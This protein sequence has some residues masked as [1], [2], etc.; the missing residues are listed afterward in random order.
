MMRNIVLPDSH[1]TAAQ[2][3]RKSTRRS[4]LFRSLRFEWLESRELLFAGDLDSAFGVGGKVITEFHDSSAW[5]HT[6]YSSVMQTNGKIVAAG[7]GALSRYHSDGSLDASFGDGGK[8]A[9]PYF[10]RSVALQSDGKIVVAGSVSTYGVDFAVARYNANGTVDTTFDT[11]GMVTTD[12]GSTIDQAYGVAVQ[13][14][15]KILVVGSSGDSLAVV[16]YDSNGT[17]DS[18]FNGDGKLLKQIH[19]RDVVRSVAVQ[20]DGRI[21][22]AGQSFDF[23]TSGS[24]YDFL[25]IRLLANGV[26]DNS[27]DGDGQTTTGFARIDVANSVALQS[28][29]KIVV[30]GTAQEFSTSTFAVARYNSDGKLDTTFDADGVRTDTFPYV[31]TQ[32]ND[33]AVQIDGRIVVAGQSG[34]QTALIRYNP[35]GGL[36]FSFGLAGKVLGAGGSAKSVSLQSDGKP[37]VAGNSAGK[38]SVARYS[39]NGSSDPTFSVDGRVLTDFGP[40]YDDATAMVLQNDGKIIVAGQSERSFALARYNSNGS[41]DKSFSGDGKLTLDFGIDSL[42]SKATSVALQSDGKI[43]VAGYVRFLVGDFVYSDFAVARL[44]SDGS[45]DTSFSGDGKLITDLG[46]FDNAFAVAV[47][48]N[49]KILVGGGTNEGFALVRFNPDGSADTSFDADGKQTTPF[50]ASPAQISSLALQPDGK[51]LAAGGIGLADVS[52]HLTVLAIARYN[53][54]GSLDQ[55]FDGDGIVLDSGSVQRFASDIAV[56]KD[57]RIVV[58]GGTEELGSSGNFQSNFAVSRYLITGARDSSFGS[59]GTRVISFGDQSVANRLAL[60]ADNSVLAAGRAGDDFAL[61]R[62]NADGTLDSRFAGDGKLTTNFRAG[63]FTA[64]SVA[65]QRDG[66][67]VAA[68]SGTK[69]SE[70]YGGQ[71]FCSGPIPSGSRAD[72]FDCGRR[73]CCRWDH[74]ERPVESG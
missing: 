36:D 68:G 32:A 38:F 70:Q 53:L 74:C 12:L 50:D 37:V 22:L 44:N 41:L 4:Q 65:I 18:G 24:N 56:Q 23:H 2:I 19:T 15:G 6:A 64:T 16:R 27:F 7:E 67:I 45:L 33:V 1:S 34:N 51:I 58:S 14:N 52:E 47:Q 43:V 59:N 28:N 71:R 29:G 46:D 17:L 63:D 5:S 54:N 13:A 11:D 69:C 25:V 72:F 31:G 66:M 21:V 8:V 42:E 35:I 57:S 9:F 3:P 73:E 10:A 55:T 60:Q 26:L 62:F 49:G 48:P 40:S 20:S 30:V 39:A 61:A